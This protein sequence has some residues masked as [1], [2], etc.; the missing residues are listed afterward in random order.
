M[1]LSYSKI[2]CLLRCPRQF[3]LKY[4]ERVE[5]LVSPY[6]YLGGSAHETIAWAYRQKMDGE[7]P[8]ADDLRNIFSQYWDSQKFLEDEQEL[9]EVNWKEE[10]PS[11]L[12]ETGALLCSLYWQKIAPYI[13]PVD[14]EVP[15]RREI[16]GITLVGKIDLI[17]GNGR[18]VDLKTKKRGFS[19][20]EVQR[21]LQPSLYAL[22][23]GS[24]GDI[25]FDFHQMVKTKNP[26][27]S[28]VSTR[29]SAQELS[30]VATQ[31]LP[32]VAR[33]VESGNFYPNPQSF[34]CSPEN[35]ETWHWCRGG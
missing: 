26:Y 15:F 2:S 23:M 28:V 5:H 19:E 6:L 31:L 12:R 3:E 7:E 17:T 29:R 4:L 16:G 11:E 33:A 21:E 1:Q 35:C 25:K 34:L 22:G 13:E 14:V 9:R 32:K 10:S 27:V 8:Q 20:A 30:W 18:L 24:R